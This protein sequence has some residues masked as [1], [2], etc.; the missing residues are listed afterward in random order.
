MS[1]NLRSL[2]F[3]ISSSS[4]IFESFELKVETFFDNS[5]SA[6]SI[7]LGF[8]TFLVP[9]SSALI[10]KYQ[11]SKLPEEAFPVGFSF[12]IFASF[13]LRV[14]LG[15]TFIKLFLASFNLASAAFIS[16]SRTFL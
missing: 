8:F 14:C 10:A 16:L 7:A 12:Q 11:S 1:I 2:S 5:N 13:S 9:K 3:C 4:R 15:T 6:L